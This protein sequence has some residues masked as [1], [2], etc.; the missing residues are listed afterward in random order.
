MLYRYLIM[1]AVIMAM[2]ADF[3]RAELQ[4][5]SKSA[6][7]FNNEEWKVITR[8]AALSEVVKENPWIVRNLLDALDPQRNLNG[9]EKTEM[10]LEHPPD[11]F[12]P[13]ENPD[14]DSLQRA[15]PEAVHDLFQ[16]LKLAAEKKAVK[17]K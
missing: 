5:I 17:S 11:S 10:P 4:G 13:K 15:S 16:L 8:N 12:D 6:P 7:E 3:G 2:T 14:V 1:I 9:A